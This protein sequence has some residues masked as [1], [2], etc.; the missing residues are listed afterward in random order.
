MKEIEKIY[1]RTENYGRIQFVKEIYKLQFQR[2]R[3]VSFLENKIKEYKERISMYDIWHEIGEDIN[4]L[5][6]KKQI[7]Q[8]VLDFIKSDNDEL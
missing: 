8:E 7:Y 1:K 6:L 2:K 3:Y 5:I 4:F